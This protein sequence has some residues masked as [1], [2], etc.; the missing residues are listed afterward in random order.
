[1]NPA[2]NKHP[3]AL[4]ARGSHPKRKQLQTQ[5]GATLI[6]VLVAVLLLAIGLFGMVGLQTRSMIINQSSLQ[7][8]QAVMLSYFFFDSI[9][10]NLTAAQNGDYAL[11][12]TCQAPANASTAIEQDQKRLLDAAKQA[13]GNA[14]TTCATVEFA[15]GTYT[16]TLQWDDSRAGG[17]AN[18]TF[19]T[20]GK[21]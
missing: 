4:P 10:A 6:E 21:P 9:R 13:L 14:D 18:Q 19:T 7:R 17:L 11:S 20:T 1:M 8:S 3:Q 2:M 12:K 5:K 16:L 15:G